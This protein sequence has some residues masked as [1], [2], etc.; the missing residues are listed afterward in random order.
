MNLPNRLT[1]IR[2]FCVPVFMVFT[3]TDNVYTRVLALLIFIGAG[4]TDLYDGYLA[5]KYNMVTSLGM[6][7]DPLADK[8]IVTAAFIS[9]VE[10]PEV[11]VPAWMVVLIV[12]REFFMTGLRSLAAS[13]G[14]DIPA[15]HMGK[16][17]TTVQNTTIITIMVIL[18]IN[19]SLTHFW[20][21]SRA[22]FHLH[23]GW[24]FV[25]VRILDWTPYWMMFLA[26][27]FTLISGIS[28]FRKNLP[29][30]KSAA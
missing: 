5:R 12:G 6:F 19:S 17:K 14:Q 8:M 22:Q 15:D 28:Y 29:L 24:R 30:L 23:I 7:L 27:L 18:I 20:Q 13:K 9:F 2:L 10:L 26:T 11:N 1:I 21:I 25:A 4:V 3:Y 16:F